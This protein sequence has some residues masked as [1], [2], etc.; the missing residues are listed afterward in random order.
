MYKN[1]IK[2][3]Q[4][5][6]SCFP[7]IQTFLWTEIS[8]PRVFRMKIYILSSL[9]GEH[10]VFMASVCLH[11][12]RFAMVSMRASLWRIL[13]P[14]WKALDGKVIFL[15]CLQKQKRISHFLSTAAI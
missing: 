12:E 1:E 4:I 5:L 2:A 6:I 7:N 3:L 13:I 15:Y 10:Y 11:T 14:G 8:F 9:Q